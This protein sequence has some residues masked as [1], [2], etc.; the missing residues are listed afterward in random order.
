MNDEEIVSTYVTKVWGANTSI[1]NIAAP[2]QTNITTFT[3]GTSTN[4]II[5]TTDADVAVTWT[6]IG[7]S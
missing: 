4:D 5:V 6:F 2:K 3:I 7:G 1:T